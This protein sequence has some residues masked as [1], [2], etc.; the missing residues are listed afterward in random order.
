MRSHSPTRAR[1][2]LKGLLIVL[3]AV[4][5]AG[6]GML[7]ETDS[8]E[9]NEITGV[10][11]AVST[12]NNTLTVDGVVY[13]V[14]DDTEFEGLSGLSDLS[15]GEEV[16]IEYEEENGERIATEIERPDGDDDD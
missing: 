3:L 2:V 6:C 4:G 1:L 8:S 11:E 15:S 5:M 12:Q 14:T 7:G 9:E 10:V 16:G 13:T